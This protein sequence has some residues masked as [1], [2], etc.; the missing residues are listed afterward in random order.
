MIP[1]C[2]ALL[3]A[4][5]ML[6]VYND[7]AELFQRS[8]HS[9]AR[10]DDDALLAP[11]ECKPCIV[12]LAIAQRGVKNCNPVAEHGAES[13]DGLRCQRYLGHEHDCRLSAHIHDLAKQLNVHEC[14]SAAGYSV[15][16]KYLGGI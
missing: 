12:P 11:L 10:A 7:G 2:L 14:F 16:K 1:G 13:V 15:K 9:R 8:E 3:V 4:G 6:F 5:F